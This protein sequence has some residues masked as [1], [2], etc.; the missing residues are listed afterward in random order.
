MNREVQLKAEQLNKR[1]KHRN[2][3]YRILSVP[4]CIVVFI[5][6]YAMILPAITLESTPDTY[7]GLEEHIH[8]DECYETPSVPAHKEIKCSA[9]D[10]LAEGEYIVHTHNS[11]CFD[12][13]GELICGLE[14]QTEHT[15]TDECYKNGKLVCEKQTPVIHQHT[16][17]CVVTVPATEPQGLICTKTEHRHTESCFIN[18]ESRLLNTAALT[19]AET[20]PDGKTDNDST[21]AAIKNEKEVYTQNGTTTIY[22]SSYSDKATSK[23]ESEF[24]GVQTDDGKVVTDKTVIYGKDDYSAFSTY[25]QNTFSVALSA[26]GQQYENTDTTVIK[27]PLDIVFILDTSGS[28]V[29]DGI[30]RA[31]DAV[32]TLNELAKYVME[33]N[34]ENRFGIATF[35]S[36]SSNT[37][38]NGFDSNELLPIGSYG[39]AKTG[40]ILTYTAGTYRNSYYNATVKV[41]TSV[42][43]TSSANST[44][45]YGGTYTTAGYYKAAQMLQNTTG[46]TVTVNG[47]EI[48]RVPIVI[49]ITDGATTY[50]SGGT[51]KYEYSSTKNRNS[52]GNS[53]SNDDLFYTILSA[54]HYKQQVSS[55]YF[56][57]AKM[58]TVGIGEDAVSDIEFQTNLDPTDT[59]ISGLGSDYSTAKSNLLN[60]SNFPSSYTSQHGTE[61][62]FCNGTYT[63]ENFDPLLTAKLKEFIRENAGEYIYSSSS[64]TE[65]NIEMTDIIGS[66]MELK[67]G[68]VLRYD[69]TNYPLSLT[70][71]SGGVST[72]K[73]TG[74]VTVKANQ[75]GDPVSLSEITVTVDTTAGG[76]Q[77]VTWDLPSS[78]LPEYTHA[79]TG[80]W[81][82]PML[83]VRLLYQVGLTEESEQAVRNLTDTSGEL[84]FYTNAYGAGINNAVAVVEPTE[85]SG[86]VSYNPYYESYTGETKNKDEN[87]TITGS[88][89]R[90]VTKNGDQINFVMGNNGKLVF[91]AYTKTPDE[92]SAKTSVVAKKVW[93][94][95]NGSEI[96]D[97]SGLPGI[98]AVAKAD[99]IIKYTAVLNAANEWTHTFDNLPTEWDDGT[100]ITWTVDEESVPSGYEKE[101][102][103]DSG[104]TTTSGGSSTVTSLENGGI[105]VFRNRSNYS[106]KNSS[107][108]TI[109][110]A[111]G[112]DTDTTIQWKAIAQSNGKFR[113][114]NVSTGNY[115]AVYATSSRG[116]T[117]YYVTA[118]G[119]NTSSYVYDFTLTDNELHV[120]VNNT[121]RRI[122]IT[123]NTGST[124]GTQ[125]SSSQTLTVL[126]VT[127]VGSSARTFTITNKEKSTAALTVTK[128]VRASDTNGEF[129]FEIS[130][131]GG[132]PVS[133]ALKNG[134]T[135]TLDDIAI[136]SQVTLKEL[137]SDGYS[138]SFIKDGKTV[139]S[140]VDSYAF[141]ADGDISLTVQNTAGV[142]LPETGGRGTFLWIYGGLGIMLG[143]V[144][145]GY[146]LRRRYRKEGN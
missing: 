6:T 128:T 16:A 28:M 45:F 3:W 141:T 24:T 39:N 34:S 10:N 135:Y 67:S 138:V 124:I 84:T 120:E 99:G 142:V 72:Y 17:E 113:L 71:T 88:A 69:G 14:E 145:T 126:T 12:D 101:S 61:Y 48:E 121:D 111:T 29:A 18:P 98:T 94:D 11:F 137:N 58:Y 103:E 144:V 83:P 1:R 114:Q 143:A 90:E 21:S 100:E 110:S 118:D 33:L 76:N 136:G 82:Y 79:K 125:T 68:F 4:V 89:Y 15:H 23:I 53:M 127:K 97:T 51:N 146:F 60:K 122:R 87:T 133:F 64:R 30:S 50:S 116:L 25:D 42:S 19:A 27:T 74:S 37:Y 26:L 112:E 96:T 92:T 95:K 59:N 40:D 119:G 57:N 123:S 86:D 35:S 2:I 54:Y 132:T 80:S 140:G 115:L 46:K 22:R 36:N 75:Y 107:G 105:Y 32:K 8:G 13:K 108:S 62:Y 93:K 55:A 134:E 5:T 131:D 9:A 117:S 77:R 78:L 85:A 129:N 66:G 91:W 47:Q 73:Y 38:N 56:N 31:E 106:I 139:Q 43:G 44:Y 81:Y 52:T 102:V 49:L 63:S 130:V 70:G 104:A 7:C 20:Q 65:T 41:N 109:S